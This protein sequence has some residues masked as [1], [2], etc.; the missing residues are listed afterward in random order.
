MSKD[1][2]FYFRSASSVRSV[3]STGLPNLRDL[4]SRHVTD[5]FNHIV[6]VITPCLS[7]MSP[8][9]LSPLSHMGDGTLDLGL[10]AGISRTQNAKFITDAMSKGANHVRGGI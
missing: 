9:G 5:R 8:D 2:E 6:A 7:R 4:Y 10:I 3:A 1:F